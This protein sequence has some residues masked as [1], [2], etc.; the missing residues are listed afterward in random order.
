MST[1]PQ[2]R[3]T[4]TTTAGRHPARFAGL[5]FL[6]LFVVA[7]VLLMA[8]PGVYEGSTL[9]DYAAGHA[10]RAGVARTTILAIFAMPLA[11]AALVVA[12][13][14]LQRR[15]DDASGGPTVATRV[16]TLGAAIT[17]AGL[18]IAAAAASAAAHV[19]GGAADGGFPADA[20]VGY[21][22][23]MLGSQVF[24]ASSWGLALL[25]AGVAVAARRTGQLSGW[26]R[27]VAFVVAPL[28]PVAWIFGMLP[29][30]AVLLWLPAACL[31]VENGS[32]EVLD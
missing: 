18:T 1:I 24:A 3:P 6:V 10:D 2:H 19:A 23:D 8:G 20:A 21:G 30:L 5:A 32:G 28:L 16:A 7:F 13:V 29:L 31:M 4:E 15:L 27:W 25:V 9:V 11:A 14:H 12:A 17:A 26:M 22:L